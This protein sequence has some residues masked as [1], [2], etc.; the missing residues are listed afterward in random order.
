MLWYALLWCALLCSLCAGL[1]AHCL[2]FKES[3]FAA[4]NRSLAAGP[5]VA[6]AVS[7]ALC[8]AAAGTVVLRPQGHVSSDQQLEEGE[9]EDEG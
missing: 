2:P 4:I 1:V 3:K 5:A 7:G 9:E 8:M 6:Q